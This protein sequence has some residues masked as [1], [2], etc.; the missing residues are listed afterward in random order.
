[1]V[2]GPHS[3]ALEG[4]ES[5]D[6]SKHQNHIL[7]SRAAHLC[8]QRRPADGEIDCL[9]VSSVKYNLPVWMQRAL[10]EDSVN[11]LEELFIYL[12]WFKDAA[13]MSA[14][15]LLSAIAKDAQGCR[16]NG[17][18]VSSA[19]KREDAFVHTEQNGSFNH[20]RV[21]GGLWGHHN[22]GPPM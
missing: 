14:F 20:L 7:Y 19:F 21:V 22:G 11:E 9:T 5:S 10:A 4:F 17:E 12:F 6:V 2:D 18:D 16:I 1:M 8:G 15:E 3:G 13:E